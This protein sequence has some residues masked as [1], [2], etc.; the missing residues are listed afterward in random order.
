[1]RE[2]YYHSCGCGCR[3]HRLLSCMSVTK[4]ALIQYTLP[5][6]R[7]RLFYLEGKYPNHWTSKTLRQPSTGPTPAADP[8]RP[9]LKTP[10]NFWRRSEMTDTRIELAT[11]HWV[12]S[13]IQ[14][15]YHCANPPF[16]M[17][18]SAHSPATGAQNQMSRHSRHVGTLRE[19]N[20]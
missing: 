14:S 13:S 12:A 4:M 20:P 19:S 10:K 2:S 5:G 9:L 11:Q 7:T 8:T 6:N 3:S 18:T 1:M 15:R 16:G 17:L